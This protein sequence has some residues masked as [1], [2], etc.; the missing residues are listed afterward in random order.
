[1]KVLH[2]ISGV[3][4]WSHHTLRH[5]IV[6]QLGKVGVSLEVR[7][8]VINHK[9]AGMAGVYNHVDHEDATRAA[10]IKW[11]GMIEAQVRRRRAA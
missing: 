11:A 4:G 7:E 10:L 2:E 8:A 1:M 5:T 6:S 3:T 9:L